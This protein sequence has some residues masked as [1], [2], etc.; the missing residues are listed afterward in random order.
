M[1]V[2][3][4]LLMTL[5]AA[6]SVP[7]PTASTNPALSATAGWYIPIIPPFGGPTFNIGPWPSLA[8]CNDMD[9][10]AMYKHG[11]R[12]HITGSP[13]DCNIRGN[14]WAYPDGTPYPPPAEND[15]KTRIAGGCF[16]SK[17]T[18]ALGGSH[19]LEYHALPTPGG[20]AP[21]CGKWKHYKAL[22]K[23]DPTHYAIARVHDACGGKCWPAGIDNAC[24]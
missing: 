10:S 11:P 7:T 16:F 6:T 9:G 1:K 22:V 3:A 20:S 14:G 5:V 4:L 19:F 8:E 13:A 2:L 21:S 23:A 17:T 24:E 18:P 12:C 15:P